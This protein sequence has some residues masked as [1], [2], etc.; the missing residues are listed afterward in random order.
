MCEKDFNEIIARNISHFMQLNGL[1]QSDLAAKL[2]V[3][4]ASISNWINARKS[5]RMDK[6]DEMCRLFKIKRSDLL[7]DHSSDKESYFLDTESQK[8]ADDIKNNKQLKL[9]FSA[10]RDVSPENLE[11]AHQML[12]ALKRREKGEID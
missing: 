1:T 12:L 6:V 2:D 9:L 10:A 7:I 4:E 3:S 8:I 11:L 5:P